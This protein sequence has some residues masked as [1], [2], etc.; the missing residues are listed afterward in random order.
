M[1]RGVSRWG[2]RLRRSVQFF[3]LLHAQ[4]PGVHRRIYKLGGAD[5]RQQ[6]RIRLPAP[7]HGLRNRFR[8]AESIL[9]RQLQ[10]GL[11]HGSFPAGDDVLPPFLTD[12]AKYL[13]DVVRPLQD[14]EETVYV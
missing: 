1:R 13:K 5:R 14:K 6:E 2:Y 9:R 10:V 12:R 8:V 11:L 3:R 7:S 4:L